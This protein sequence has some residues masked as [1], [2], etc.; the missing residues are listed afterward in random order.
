MNDFRE[1]LEGLEALYEGRYVSY[2]DLEVFKAKQDG[3]LLNEENGKKELRK[4]FWGFHFI[5]W[6]KLRKVIKRIQDLLENRNDINREFIRKEQGKKYTIEGNNLDPQQIEA[7][8]AC[9]DAELILAPAGS[10]KSASLLA[11]INYLVDELK[12]PAERV[13]VIAFTKKVV[14]EL[15]ERVGNSKVNISTFHSLGNAIIRD[16]EAGGV[17]KKV[18]TDVETKRFINETIKSLKED[19]DF[20]KKFNDYLMFYQ[21][22]PVDLDELK[23]EKEFIDF[24]R[25]YLRQTLKTVS[26]RKK[27]YNINQPT[28]NQ[29]YVK[30][31]EEQIIA[32]W[33]F[34]NQIEYEY[35]KQYEHIDSW[36]HPDFTI[37]QF[38]EPIYYEHFA[39]RK[40]GTSPF[41]NYV[42]EME[43]KRD[44][45][46]RNGTTLIETYSYEWKDGTLLKNL[47]QRLKEAGLKII[48]RREE[49]I[50]ALLKTDAKYREDLE[51][52][53]ELFISVL[54]LQKNEQIGILELKK[55]IE[56]I[57]NDYIRR[58]A[59]LFYELYRPIYEAYEKYLK[60]NNLYDFA[61]MLNNATKIVKKSRDGS[62]PYDYILVDEVQDLSRSKYLLLKA[63]LDKSGKVKLFAVGDDWQSIYRFAGSNLKVLSDFE[64]IFERETYRGLIELTYRFGEPTAN[65]SGKFIQKNPYQS[66]KDVKSFRKTETPIVLALNMKKAEKETPADYETV[67]EQIQ[68]LYEELGDKLFEKRVQ[69]ISRYNRDIY[70]IVDKKEHKYKNA[71]LTD[72]TES[73]T[74]ITWKIA[75]TKKQLTVPFCS[76]HKSKG[77]TRDIVFVINMNAGMLGMPSTRADE[78]VMATMLAEIDPYPLAEERRLFYVAITRAVERTIIVAEASQVSRFVYEISPNL[79]GAGV[80]ICPK[81]KSGILVER[82]RRRDGKK[83]YSCSNYVNGCKYATDE[84]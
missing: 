60:K 40:D 24:N 6:W 72:A 53:E 54:S 63:I 74:E 31:K 10:G 4:L 64:K 20:A 38:S 49:E 30:S 29:E 41:E 28:Y 59:L 13:L 81:C 58:R 44:L 66:H 71:E 70:R 8:V 84:I 16:A 42:E 62:M 50:D 67:N 57:E 2:D 68:K 77:I 22:V 55:K 61:D 34:V 5:K 3:K 69:I 56:G 14:K 83:F 12:I 7:V 79:E 1:L 73:K 9:E 48:R 32:N 23:E 35:E 43:W 17:K 18:V 78:P 45:H 33:L 65:V 27:N 26:L 36:Y 37:T 46:R 76:M 52:L 39:I 15:K 19:N 51:A 11:K 80:H 75:G 21:S 47:E 25:T 82:T